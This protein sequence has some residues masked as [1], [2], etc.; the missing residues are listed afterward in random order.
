[1]SRFDLE[2]EIMDCWSI[3]E[4]LKLVAEFNEGNKETLESLATIY[5]LKFKKCF[6]TFSRCIQN[7]DM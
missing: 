1:M 5:E 2:Q 7:G 4:D 6:N 3:V